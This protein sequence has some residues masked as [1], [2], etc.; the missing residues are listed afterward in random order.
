MGDTKTEGGTHYTCSCYD[1]NSNHCYWKPD[2]NIW[3]SDGGPVG[4]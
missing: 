1:R 3:W 2:G 4:R